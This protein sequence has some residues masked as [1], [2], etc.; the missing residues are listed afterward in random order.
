LRARLSLTPPHSDVACALARSILCG[1]EAAQ[2]RVKIHPET[3][4]GILADVAALETILGIA[5]K[6]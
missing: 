3:K 1:I 4:A 2:I 5:R 6:A